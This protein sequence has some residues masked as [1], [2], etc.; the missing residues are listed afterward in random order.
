[1]TVT[2][3]TLLQPVARKPFDLEAFFMDEFP[4]RLY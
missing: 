1:M 4:I 3:T 2:M